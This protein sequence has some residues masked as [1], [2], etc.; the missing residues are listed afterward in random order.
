ML[1]LKDIVKVY[2]AG[3]TKVTALKKI[4]INFR[5]NEFVSILGPSGCGK[6]TLLNIIGGL[7]RYTSGDLLINDVSTKKYN[8]ENWDSYRNHSIGFVFQSYNLIP[9][10]TVLGNVELALTLSGVSR[11][12]RKNRAIKALEQVGLSD[13]INKLP[14]QLSGG[15]MQRVAIA[16]AIV[17]NPDII[18]ADEPTGALD[19]ETSIQVMEILKG[20]AKDRLVIM[21]TH[22]PDLANK[23]STRII[24]LLDGEI[25]DDS[26]PY[27][28]SDNT[29]GAF[30]K[31][32]KAKK[33]SMSFLTAISLSLKNLL[34]KKGRTF[35]TAF[36]GSIGIIGIALILSLS[37]GFQ[38]YI[39]KIE[40]DTLSSYPITI[41]ETSL[42]LSSFMN[43]NKKEDKIK[44]K[45]PNKIYSDNI[46]TSLLQN[47]LRGIKKNDLVSLKKYLDSN[48]E[49]KQYVSS[50]KY[51]YNA[52][53]NIYK[54]DYSEYATQLVPYK[55][56]KYMATIL[57]P[58]YTQIEMLMQSSV[59]WEE[60]LDNQE[61][62]DSQYDL[63]KG[64]WPTNYDEV[65]LVVNEDNEL[66]DY[67][68]YALGLRQESE[69]QELLKNIN[70][71]DY[72]D[73]VT[74]YS[75]DELLGLTYKLV[76]DSSYYELQEN[77]FWASKKDDQEYLKKLLD[78]AL[79]IK[80]VGIIRPKENVKATSISGAIGY[81]K[82]LTDYIVNENSKSDVIVA[83]KSLYETEQKSIFDGSIIDDNQYKMIMSELGDADLSQ[84][85]SISIYPNSFESKDKII[86]IINDYNSDKSSADKIQYTD[87]IGLMM[88]SV[89]TIINAITYILVAFVAISLVVSSI[90]IGI[91]T[92][93]SVLERTK[94]IGVLR[95]IGA[96]RKDVSRVFNAETLIIGFVAGT[97]GIL[98]TILLCIPANLIIN[99]YTGIGNVAKLPAVGGIILVFIS[100]GLTLFA[101]LIPSSIASKKDPVLALRSE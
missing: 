42:D 23:Y 97:L 14:N 18:L 7:D 31:V 88:S 29:F 6:T 2:I 49:L 91:I 1:K 67:I 37:N 75:L 20:I 64:A 58:S 24:K 76:V 11:N 72:V 4:S 84:P 34:T 77:G 79:D 63:L 45:D 13:Q 44:D 38:R 60:M 16:R 90:M 59:V 68:L 41:E 47:Y 85:S 71:P 56:P 40:E 39:S 92:Y 101:G 53:I 27:D 66:S 5:K 80:I 35:L 93:I 96:S 15:Q 9:H 17:N 54:S 78:K 87:Y 36:A 32:V 98:I 25:I 43:Y 57:G 61:L 55:I 81:T 70:N 46:M 33:T 89:T 10:Q 50:I 86:K 3:E 82:Q 62:I 99:H 69:L 22:N 51:N 12:E 52:N 73:K 21:V 30:E 26:N 28:G 74:E 19:T 100:M 48:E 94:E 65:V 95:S 8:N 83:Q